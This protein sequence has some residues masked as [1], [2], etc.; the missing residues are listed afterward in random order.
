MNKKS[1]SSSVFTSLDHKLM[2]LDHIKHDEKLLT[3]DSFFTRNDRKLS[4][5]EDMKILMSIGSSSM[6]K[7]LFRYFNYD[8]NTVSLPGF[9]KSRAKIKDEA[10]KELLKMINKAY[11][12][13]ANLI[14][15]FCYS[16]MFVCLYLRLYLLYSILTHYEKTIMFYYCLVNGL[17]GLMQRMNCGYNNSGLTESVAKGYVRL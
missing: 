11:P 8:I 9:I 10:F 7:E 3:R 12:T 2:K 4:F 15:V 17:S 1:F 14:S 6:K 5:I 16:F 13:V